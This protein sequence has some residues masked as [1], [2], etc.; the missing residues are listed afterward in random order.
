VIGLAAQSLMTR[1]LVRFF[2]QRNRVASAL[3]TPLVFWLLVGSGL[4]KSFRPPGAPESVGPLEYFFPGTLLMIVLFTAIFATISIIE[5]RKEGFLQSVLVAPVPRAGIVLGKM[6]GGTALAAIQVLPLLALAP[7]A[8]LRA[9]VAG[10]LLA[11]GILVV[12]AFGLT[13]LGFLIAWRL[14]STQGFHAIMNLFLLPMWMLSGAF[15]PA[16]G[17][18]GWL[19]VVM[20]ANPMTYALAALRRGIYM[21]AG[22]PGMIDPSLPGLGLSLVVAVVFA[23]ATFAVAVQQAGRTT[24]GDLQ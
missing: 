11:A 15:F 13:G 18:P 20:A 8:G 10:S 19:Q 5:D 21:G 12:V 9:S 4:G 22:E 24:G 2:R 17:A 6:L 16:S 1:E 7:L 14:D 3:L 23:A